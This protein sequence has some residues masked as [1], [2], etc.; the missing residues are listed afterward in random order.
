MTEVDTFTINRHLERVL[1]SE[2]LGRSEASRRLL[3]Y[4]VNRSLQNAVPKETE[5]ALDVF[6]KDATFNGAEDSVVRVAVRTLRQKLVEYYATSAPN[7]E[8]F[9]FVIAKGGYRVTTV[10]SPGKTTPD[11]ASAATAPSETSL[12]P[13]SWRR[14]WPLLL[15][16][17][18]LVSLLANVWIYRYSAAKTSDTATQ[19]VRASPIWHGIIASHRPLTIVLG[20]LFMFSQVDAQTGRTLTVR[21]TRINSSEDLRAFLAINPAFAADRGQR[22]VS[23][24]QKAATIS[25]V[26]ILRMVD[27]PDRQIDVTVSD[28]LEPEDVRNH[29][30]IYIGPF[31]GLGALSGYYQPRSRYRMNAV[32]SVL[33][34]V[35]SH[36]VFAPQGTLGAERV[37]YAIVAEIVGPSGNHILILTAGARNAGILQVARTVTSSEGLSELEAQLKARPNTNPNSFE[38]LLTIT[39]YR[40]TD[41]SSKVVEVNPLSDRIRLEAVSATR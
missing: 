19:R 38:A 23:M 35:E 22:Y 34:N 3:T 9:Q 26:G 12:R 40:Q 6:G 13:R 8:G 15:C 25:M 2:P 18:L 1:N 37:D 41:L 39:G 30:I 24:L 4:L 28:E 7:P 21:D 36:K 17:L 32:D 16:S 14:P 10:A 29:D 31:S 5:I 20:D 27:R 33:T 11:Q